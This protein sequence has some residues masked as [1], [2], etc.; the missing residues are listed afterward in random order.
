[1]NFDFVNL[2]FYSSDVTSFSS[3]K[4]MQILI[5]VLAKYGCSLYLVKFRICTDRP[6]QS[7]IDN[8][9]LRLTF[10]Y[11]Q[12]LL[13]YHFAQMSKIKRG[14]LNQCGPEYFEV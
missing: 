8:L 14:G 5:K 3:V 9:H 1:V 2:Q 10:V 7:H 12:L 4:N 13:E 6:N 11:Q